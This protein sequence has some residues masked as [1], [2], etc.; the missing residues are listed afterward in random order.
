MTRQ[1]GN[2]AH[3]FEGPVFQQYRHILDLL[4]NVRIGCILVDLANQ[5]EDDGDE[6]DEEMTLRHH[7]SKE[8]PLDV[9]VEFLSTLLYSVR[10]E[11]PAEVLELV[12]QAIST[13]LVEYHPTNGVPFPIPILDL[14][15]HS[16]GQGPTQLVLAPAAT[17][18]KKGSKSAAAA[19]AVRQ[20]EVANPTYQVA[21]AV[22]RT[23]LNKVA[24]PISQLLNGLLH[25]EPY[26]VDQSS[27]RCLTVA[28]DDNEVENQKNNG[29]N[30]TAAV[31]SDSNDNEIYN[32]I[33]ELH[34]VAPQILATVLGTVANGLRSAL[35]TQRYQV[36]LL[37]GRLFAVSDM[38]EEYAACFREWLGRKLDVDP[39]IRLCVMKQCMAILVAVSTK[40][41][42]GA[43]VVDPEIA[44]VTAEA[45]TLLVTSDPSLDVRM[46][47]IHLICDWAYKAAAGSPV[48]A[49]LLQ[50]VG[51]RV[52]AKHKQERRDAVTGLAHVYFRQYLQPHLK[53]VIEGG[54]DCDIEIIFKALHGT[55]HLEPAEKSHKRGSRRQH[56]ED[57]TNVLDEQYRWIPARVLECVYFTDQ[58]DTEMRS[59]V[60][61]IVDEL[62]LGSGKKMTPTA[63]AIGWTAML[64]SVVE[65]GAGS[66]L[67]NT[68]GHSNA[69]KFLQQMLGQRAALQKTVSRYIDARTEIRE[70]EAGEYDIV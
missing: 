56:D 45:L 14:L 39:N 60:V 64:D 32:I 9:F 33:F 65:G 5:R 59:R 66:L 7:K 3:T 8:T 68:G 62:L 26:V 54:D 11:H 20:M 40:R 6:E 21:A 50:A 15:L 35:T 41:A 36:T 46:E 28:T 19:G 16:I 2:L 58:T 49:S 70:Y 61:Q 53:A 24:T 31:E 30:K 38:A 18:N 63:Q 34:R 69:F 48:T 44:L 17:S 29:S 1:L 23:L 10:R 67:L 42:P 22:I 43:P 13:C 55:C 12:Q 51:S 47:A 52:S 27:I 25:R 4:A 57:W 37:L